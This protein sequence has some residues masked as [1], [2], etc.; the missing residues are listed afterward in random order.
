MFKKLKSMFG[1]RT[2]K[3][4]KINIKKSKVSSLNIPVTITDEPDFDQALVDDF[5]YSYPPFPKGIPAVNIQRIIDT[6]KDLILQIIIARG[7]A[8]KHNTEEVEQRILE[9]IRHL[10][11]IT[12]LLPATEKEHFRTPGGLFRFCLES[13]LFGIRYAERKILTRV[14]QEVRRDSESLWA[15][16]SFLTGLFSEA[17]LVISRLSVYSSDGG[18]EW[19]PGTDTLTNWL[20]ENKLRSYHIKWGEIEEPAIVLFLAG[21]AIEKSQAHILGKGEKPILIALVGALYDPKNR[22]N[23]LADINLEVRTAL[24]KRD[25]LADSGRYGRP[26]SGMHLAPWLIDAMRHLLGKKRWEVNEENGRLWYGNDGAYIIWPLG[27]EDMKHELRESRCPF[28][29]NTME[30]LAE[31]MSEAGIIDKAPLNNGYIFEIAIPQ[32]DSPDKK[33]VTALR[34]TNKEVLFERVEYIPLNMELQIFFEGESEIDDIKTE[35]LNEEIALTKE[36]YRLED[37]KITQDGIK[38][39][40]TVQSHDYDFQD[41]YVDIDILFG[42]KKAN[43]PHKSNDINTAKT[44]EQLIV[45]TEFDTQDERPSYD[46]D[47]VNDYVNDHQGQGINYPELNE[48]TSLVIN[49]PIPINVEKTHIEIVVPKQVIVPETIINIPAP[50]EW[51]LPSTLLL[52]NRES[53]AQGYS[54]KELNELSDLIEDILNNFKIEVKVVGRHPGPVI[55]LFEL[56]LATGV[57]VSRVSLL[58]KDLARGLSVNSVRVVEVIP[59]KSVIG[60]E[61]PNMVRETV[62]LKK[63]LESECFKHAESLLTMAIGQDIYGEPLIVDLKK[64]PH[65]LVAGTTG[66][67]KSVAINTMILSILYKATPDQVQLIMIDPKMLELSVYAGIP[68]L[69]FPVVTDMSEAGLTL[70][71]AIDEMD[72][73]YNL[74]SKVGAKNIEGFNKLIKNGRLTGN[75]IPN[76]FFNITDLSEEPQVLSELPFIVIIIDELADMLMNDKKIEGLIVRLAQKARAAGIHFILATQRPSSDVLTGTIKANIPARFALQVSSRIDSRTI[77]DQAGAESL[78]GSGDMLFMA[79]GSTIPVRAH[80]SYIDDIEINRVVDFLKN[81]D[82]ACYQKIIPKEVILPVIKEL[83]QGIDFVRT[84]VVEDKIVE[85]ESH[86]ITDEQELSAEGID[87]NKATP[88]QSQDQSHRI[89]SEEHQFEE[90]IDDIDISLLFGGQK[91]PTVRSTD[92][93]LK[94]RK[95]LLIKRLRKIPRQFLESKGKNITKV[96]VK[97]IKNSNLDIKDCVVVLKASNLLILVDGLET[98]CEELDGHKLQYFLVKCDLLNG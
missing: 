26:L 63:I 72:R 62:W 15:H 3:N 85:L 59:G 93:D 74:L 31:L 66:S 18:I 8:G 84:E 70:N 89:K 41:E 48:N 27:A 30:I 71:K 47:Y 53:N 44:V 67:G 51:R 46:N 17:I 94:L 75:L 34:L 20:V 73:R 40:E 28:V 4:T 19:H 14:N 2:K 91:K 10:A 37:E 36:E 39:E 96:Q 11:G 42:N 65:V 35:I 13:A 60:L 57:K 32:S 23:K 95:D 5:V 64:M 56:E 98:G 24:I 43:V 83:K 69:L 82:K 45:V 6:N 90:P 7:L 58:D 54:D 61:I 81:P 22:Q 33:E 77:L 87:E 12:H 49:K 76:P 29:P 25:N 80:G 68:H 88:I 9:P 86:A 1:F 21:K 50:K 92:A 52:D 79:P 78:L 16:A 38:T 97:G 55:T